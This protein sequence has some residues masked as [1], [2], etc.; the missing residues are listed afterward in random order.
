MLEPRYCPN[1]NADLQGEPIPKE[2]RIHYSKDVTH[3]SRVIGIY[4]IQ[5][6]RT[7]L[8]RCPDCSHTWGRD[9][10]NGASQFRTTRQRKG[11]K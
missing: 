6:D 10:D 1:C 3:F 9:Y 2:H 11:D 7:I 4:S 5:Q 8:W